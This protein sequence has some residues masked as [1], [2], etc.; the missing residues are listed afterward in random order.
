[1]STSNN[2]DSDSPGLSDLIRDSDS[3]ELSDLIRWLRLGRDSERQARR[4]G[5]APA[6]P[7][8]ILG[9]ALMHFVT[10]GYLEIRVT[11]R[12]IED[13]AFG[14]FVN[15]DGTFDLEFYIEAEIT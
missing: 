14:P 8:V 10:N 13:A 9:D 11:P 12:A 5:V 7:M 2:P 3:P 1:M 15:S 6:R 4:A